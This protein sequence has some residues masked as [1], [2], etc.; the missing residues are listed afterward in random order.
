MPHIDAA[1]FTKKGVKRSLTLILDEG[2]GVLECIKAG[3]IEQ[4][5]NEVKIEGVEGTIREGTINFFERSQF[6]SASLENSPVMIASGGFKLS[7]G[8]LFGSMKIAT[9]TKPPLHGTFVR[10]KAK[11]GLTLNLSFTEYIDKPVPP[12]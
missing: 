10:G 2:D 12:K 11:E 9:D 1:L 4:G 3:M 5:L 8:E 6:K 7:Y